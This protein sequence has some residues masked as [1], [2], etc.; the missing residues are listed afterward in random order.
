MIGRTSTRIQGS[1]GNVSLRA[2][3]SDSLKNI[4][5]SSIRHLIS[6]TIRCEGWQGTPSNR[7]TGDLI[8]L[9]Y[10]NRDDRIE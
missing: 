3:P 10:D 5:L 6:G 1:D 7:V 8:S 9:A 2:S 4:E